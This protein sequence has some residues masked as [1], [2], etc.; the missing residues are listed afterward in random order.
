MQERTQSYLQFLL[1]LASIVIIIAGM[2]AVA[3]VLNPILMALFIVIVSLPLTRW[4]EAKGLRHGPA[5]AITILVVIATF[6]GVFLLIGSS[7]AR[8]AADLPALKAGLNA[9]IAT[10]ESSLAARGINVTGAAAQMGLDGSQVV[11]LLATIVGGLV[12]ALSNVGFVIMY[13]IFM[14]IEAAGFPEK[15]RRGLG[16]N[17]AVLKAGR[18]TTSIGTFITIKAW[19]GFLAATGDVILLTVLG[20]NYALLWGVMS[21]LLSFIPSIGYILAL[22]PPVL[23]ALIQHGPTT[24]LIVF[25]GYWLINGVIDSIIGPHYLGQGLDLS[26]V[27]TIIAAF[28][29]GWV[30]GPIGAFL[31]LPITIGV[32]MLILEHF[33]DTR[34]MAMA[35]ASESSVATA[36]PP[37][38]EPPPGAQTPTGVGK[39]S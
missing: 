25:F 8:F 9:Q 34:W 13:F 15:L 28:F 12:S 7:L 21:F 1:G 27:V 14:L 36:R 19:L 29:W 6:V 16:S 4:I 3:S 37:L 20:V 11:G 5:V 33:P 17:P 26:T 32:K 35:I 22:I 24:A 2:R 18:F 10:W 31:A 38:P 30:L 39:Q 23:V